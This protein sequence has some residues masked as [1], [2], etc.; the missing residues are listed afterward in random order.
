[1]A[2]GGQHIKFAFVVYPQVQYSRGDAYLGAGY[3]IL[4]EMPAFLICSR[5]SYDEIILRDLA[6]KIQ[7]YKDMADYTQRECIVINAN[8][9][10]IPLGKEI[11]GK[12]K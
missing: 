7:H 10:K 3:L 6:L 12:T 1:M 9:N 4:V 11:E 2:G 5:I 8:G